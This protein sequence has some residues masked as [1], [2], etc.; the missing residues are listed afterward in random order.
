M[1]LDNDYTRIDNFYFMTGKEG[2]ETLHP[3]LRFDNPHDSE[4]PRLIPLL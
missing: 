4:E 2:F 3:Y 1:L